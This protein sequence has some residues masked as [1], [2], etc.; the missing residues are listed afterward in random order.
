MAARSSTLAR[1]IAGTEEPGGLQSM[2][3]KESDTTKRAFVNELSMQILS[4][5]GA[6]SASWPTCHSTRQSY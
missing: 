5:T 6:V 3:C 4:N 1:R 2:G